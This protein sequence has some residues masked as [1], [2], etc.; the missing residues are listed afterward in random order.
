MCEETSGND[1][2]RPIRTLA[3]R[4]TFADALAYEQLPRKLTG[5]RKFAVIVWLALAGVGLAL[6]PESVA[7]AEHSLRWWIAGFA[8]L[9]V[10]F[11]LLVVAYNIRMRRR[12]RKRIPAACDVE[13]AEWGDHL[14]ERRGGRDVFV[15]PETIARVIRTERHV[16]IDAPDDVLIVPASAFETENE[17][18]AFAET[19]EEASRDPVQ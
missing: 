1:P 17:M 6:L 12:A 4:L 11:I 9:A 2:H 14:H 5:F 18:A 16:F 13:L 3:Y 7:G 8:L 10:Q 15:S 19:W